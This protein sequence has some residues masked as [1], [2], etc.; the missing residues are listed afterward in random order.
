[1][2]DFS[3]Y[4]LNVKEVIFIVE[5]EKFSLNKLLLQSKCVNFRDFYVKHA[6]K[7]NE[8]CMN[9]TSKKVFELFLEYFCYSECNLRDI[10]DDLL[11][12]LIELAIKIKFKD[13]IKYIVASNGLHMEIVAD[14][15]TFAKFH[16]MSET[17]N[18]CLA[19]IDEYSHKII[20]SKELFNK[21][22]LRLIHEIVSRDTFVAKEIEIFN[23]INEWR[24]VNKS[25][26]KLVL[27]KLRINLIRKR[28]FYDIVLPTG[29]ISDDEYFIACETS[30]FK[31]R[32][33]TLANVHGEPQASSRERAIELIDLECETSP[34][35][36]CPT[37]R[38]TN[39][40]ILPPM[41][42]LLPAP[43]VETIISTPDI[44]RSPLPRAP[45]RRQRHSQVYNNLHWLLEMM[46]DR[47][48][49]EVIAAGEWPLPH[50]LKQ[51]VYNFYR[52]IRREM[53]SAHRFHKPY[54]L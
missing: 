33:S 34:D 18:T 32:S 19:F 5:S 21:F 45:H 28:D 41:P 46:P 10:S 44:Q 30:K 24:K 36:N 35:T 7:E 11:F 16:D 48:K 51:R 29:L 38:P 4:E 12:K 37:A 42:H 40:T 23:A 31:P 52:K 26:I 53:I 9:S 50:A 22:S 43:F 6:S 14:V 13:L 8:I 17:V 25:D 49:S 3:M 15:Y 27:E 54:P 1:M 2:D 47:M 20:A 39:S